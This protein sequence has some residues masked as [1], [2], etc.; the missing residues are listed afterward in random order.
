M[1]VQPR[2]EVGI[3]ASKGPKVRGNALTIARD[4]LSPENCCENKFLLRYFAPR[5]WSLAG[6]YFPTSCKND[7]CPSQTELVRKSSEKLA[8][9][10]LHPHRARRFSIAHR[11]QIH[12]R[13][14]TPR[15]ALA[16]G[17][18]VNQLNSRANQQGSDPGASQTGSDPAHA[19]VR[20]W[21]TS[22]GV[23]PRACTCRQLGSETGSDNQ[24][25][26]GQTPQQGALG[27]DPGRDGDVK[28]G[29]TPVFTS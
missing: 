21:S 28:R 10:L 26:R 15:I 23:R 19:G 17:L 7:R 16:P 27:S 9:W 24:I 2:R 4:R 1:A 25:E 14:Q 3:D 18:T 11:G 6:K 20:P 13:G 12:S 22:N 29:Q 5:D 8:A